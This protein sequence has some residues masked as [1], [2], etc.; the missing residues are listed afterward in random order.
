[1]A[2]LDELADLRR[3]NILDVGTSTLKLTYALLVDVDARDAEAGFGELDSERQ[4]HVA[5]PDDAE[6]GG[7]LLDLA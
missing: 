7:A 4:A 2:A 5:Q 1:M 3:R 6:V